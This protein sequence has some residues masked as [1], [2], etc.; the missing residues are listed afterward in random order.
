M[1]MIDRRCFGAV[2]LLFATANVWAQAPAPP[3]L[4][5]KD[6]GSIAGNIHSQNVD[7]FHGA[8]I[9]A[10]NEQTDET[11]TAKTDAAGNYEFK[12]LPEATYS[13]RIDSEGFAPTGKS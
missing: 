7:L 2:V 8:T 5:G 10:R 12:N 6:P 11:S 13:V 9:T 4:P 3:T 1:N